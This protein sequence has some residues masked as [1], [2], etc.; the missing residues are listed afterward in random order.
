MSAHSAS[1]RLLDVDYS[2]KLYRRERVVEGRAYT[3]TIG[4]D[5]VQ[6]RIDA[7]SKWLGTPQTLFTEPSSFQYEHYRFLV[8]RIGRICSRRATKC[9]S[10]LQPQ[11]IGK[12]GHWVSV[13]YENGH[14]DSF[15]VG[16]EGAIFLVHVGRQYRNQS[17]PPEIRGVIKRVTVKS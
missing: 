1:M 4:F 8:E 6:R 11:L 14:R 16:I 13:A 17:A 12:E 10:W 2:N 7:M 15:I 5:E 3:N 9:D